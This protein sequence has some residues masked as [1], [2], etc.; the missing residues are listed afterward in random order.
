MTKAIKM[1]E[2]AI[3][4]FGKDP[5]YC[6]WAAITQYYI[7][8]RCPKHTPRKKELALKVEEYALAA[9]NKDI[10]ALFIL[11]HL[12]LDLDINKAVIK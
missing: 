3:K 11:L 6:L 7:Y 8:K 1:L 10:N 12:S 5:V 9:G 4:T 2:L